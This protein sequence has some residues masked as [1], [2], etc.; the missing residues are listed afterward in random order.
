M[1][2]FFCFFFLLLSMTFYLVRIKRIFFHVSYTVVCKLTEIHKHLHTQ[3]STQA[4]KLIL[5]ISRTRKTNKWKQDKNTNL[6]TQS[7]VQDKQTRQNTH[8]CTQSHVK[9]NKQIKQDKKTNLRTQSHLQEK[10]KTRQNHKFM[11][12][13]SGTRKTSDCKQD[14]THSI[15]CTQSH[16]QKKKTKSLK[17]SPTHILIQD[18]TCTS[19][20]PTGPATSIRQS[21]LEVCVSSSSDERREEVKPGEEE[22]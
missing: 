14:K 17:I 9:K 10:Q 18:T 12:G 20:R 8:L 13:I 6:C 16:E 11:H 2:V 5:A 7:H 21:P 1:Q 3:T 19:I 4:H 22:P 15:S